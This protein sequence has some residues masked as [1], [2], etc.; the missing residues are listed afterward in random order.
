MCLYF[1]N[2]IEMTTAKCKLLL[3]CAPESGSSRTECATD[4]ARL[5]SRV[6]GAY[7]ACLQ[8][9]RRRQMTNIKTRQRTTIRTITV[10]TCILRYSS[11]VDITNTN[12]QW[13]YT[14]HL[15]M[16]AMPYQ[17]I[18]ETPATTLFFYLQRY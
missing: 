17:Q 4:N 3:L 16:A 8:Q 14:R 18:N 9:V 2:F 10:S 5:A 7:C 12:V 15:K 6:S 11:M 13:R 1:L